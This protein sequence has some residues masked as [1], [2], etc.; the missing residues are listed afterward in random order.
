MVKGEKMGQTTKLINLINPEVMQDLLAAR[1]PEGLRVLPFAKVDNTLEGVPGDEVTVPR[2]NYIGDADDIGEG[3]DCE[4]VVLSAGSAK[5]K[6]KEIKKGVKITER[7]RISAKGDP[8]NQI[9]IQL[10][11]S[12]RGK[13][14]SDAIGALS[15]TPRIYDGT[16]GVISHDGIADA[17]DMFGEEIDQEKVMF[18]NPHQKTTLKKDPK[19][20]SQVE[21]GGKVMMTGEIGMVGGCRIVSSRKVALQEEVEEVKGVYTL[22]LEGTATI[23]DEI[24]INGTTLYKAEAA[25]DAATAATALKSAL[26]SDETL[27]ALFTFARSGAAITF[28]QKNGGEGS[29]P[30]V[31]VSPQATISAS[32]VITT[33][34]VAPKP[35]GYRCPIVQLSADNE[36]NEEEPAALTL[37]M[38]QTPKV[39]VDHYA[40]NGTDEVYANTFYIAALTDESKVVL[41]CFA[42]EESE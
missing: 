34:G 5:Y 18:I 35:A 22:T 26:D 23:D 8:N 28:T 19:F 21:Y 24:A 32:V 17:V 30:T 13:M 31:S 39:D 16:A 41:A 20:Q 37:Y 40:K 33:P 4:T 9:A 12:L 27:S 3:E 10:E 29:L 6:I 25:D 15:E 11:R 1:L 7:A 42:K 38:K 14:D 2:W 36:L